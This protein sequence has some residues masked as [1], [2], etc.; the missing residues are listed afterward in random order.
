MATY[1]SYTIDQMATLAG[2][3]KTTLYVDDR[4]LSSGPPTKNFWEIGEFVERV[5]HVT[6][7]LEIDRVT[8]TIADT[9]DGTYTYGYWYEIITNSASSDYSPPEIRFKLTEGGSDKHLF[10]GVIDYNSVKFDELYLD[11]SSDIRIVTFDLLSI[12]TRLRDVSA[13][14]LITELIDNRSVE[15]DPL[16]PVTSTSATKQGVH[17]GTTTYGYRVAARNAD[18]EYAWCTEFTVANADPTLTGSEFIRLQWTGL[19][20]AT[21]YAVYRTTSSGGGASESTGFH[22]LKG[23]GGGGTITYDDTGGITTAGATQLKKSAK[24]FVRMADIPRV[25]CQLAFSQAYHAG[26]T[27]IDYDAIQFRQSSNNLGAENCWACVYYN[28]GTLASP[29][30]SNTPY[31][32]SSHEHYWGNNFET[33][34]EFVGYVA[35]MFGLFPYAYYSDANSRIQ[36]DLL[37]RGRYGNLITVDGGLMFSELYAESPLIPKSI[38]CFRSLYAK[39]DQ[40]A[41]TNVVRAHEY[42]WNPRGGQDY[43]VDFEAHF[44]VSD[45]SDD[46]KPPYVNLWEKMY[47]ITT[48]ASTVTAT[49]CDGARYYS[50]AAAAYV[51]ASGVTDIYGN[52]VAQYE[53]AFVKYFNRLVGRR[54]ELYFRAYDAITATDGSSSFNNFRILRRTQITNGGNTKTFYANSVSRNIRDNTIE[55][56]WIEQ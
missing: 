52:T 43:D 40:D 13:A 49:A 53:E 2:T 33:S 31:F 9:R 56:E 44:S 6:N 23:S 25:A 36:L 51:N 35:K 20:G 21:D 3:V 39:D 16:G 55:I 17:T 45:A 38:R 22:G 30:M 12:I 14:D 26:V 50:H 11:G 24:L 28:S 48:G 42:T 47:Y 8:I 5:E 4:I 27:G 7:T 1:N 46:T 18:G 41:F 54:H 34:L 10:W 15:E 29:S 37:C 32:D 19:A